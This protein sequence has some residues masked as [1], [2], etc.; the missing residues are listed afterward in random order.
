MRLHVRELRG[1]VGTPLVLLH[2]WLGR[3]DDFTALAG[4]P[5]LAGRTV[6][7]VDL[8]GHGESPDHDREYDFAEVATWL[9]ESLTTPLFDLFGY[10][11]GGRVA[12]YFAATHRARVASLTLL[13]AHPGLHHPQDQRD[14]LEEDVDRATQLLM[15]APAFLAQWA[16]LPLF[17]T[18]E[19][20]P[21]RAVQARR[22]EEASTHY[23]SWARA[24]ICLS[25]GRQLPLWHLPDSLTVPT[26]LLAGRHDAKYVA[27]NGELAAANPIHCRA[28]VVDHA[29]H[30]AH[31]D[32]PHL[33]A[34]LL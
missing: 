15:D 26:T 25:T 29:A 2:G 22:E 14:R 20:A 30:A 3:G 16:A 13:G 5:A 9:A 11:M 27:L 24:L 8:P 32:A 19:A 12:L 7:A 10:S 18:R 31:L 21:W 1:G 34:T 23:Y 4:A 6:L 28:A 17:G 33:T